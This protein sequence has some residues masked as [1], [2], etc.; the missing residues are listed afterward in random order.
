MWAPDLL[1]TIGGLMNPKSRGRVATGR[2]QDLRLDTDMTKLLMVLLAVALGIAG[3]AIARSRYAEASA[4]G[5]CRQWAVQAFLAPGSREVA[6]PEGWEP[7][8]AGPGGF[9]ARRCVKE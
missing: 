8:A 6:A 1:P 5:G 9:T 7:F 4:S 3:A 2:I